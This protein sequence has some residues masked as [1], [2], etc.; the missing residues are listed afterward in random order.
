[1][2]HCCLLHYVK[3]AHAPASVFGITSSTDDFLF[4]W[5]THASGTELSR[6]HTVVSEAAVEPHL[7]KHKVVFYLWEPAKASGFNDGSWEPLVC[8]IMLRRSQMFVC[9]L[10]TALVT[11]GAVAGMQIHMA[12]L[13]TGTL[14]SV[15]STTCCLFPENSCFPAAPASFKKTQYLQCPCP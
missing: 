14:C 10:Q 3:C 1:M 15:S 6:K 13:K 11:M 9:C 4:S 5:D 8:C 2:I 12:Q 7:K